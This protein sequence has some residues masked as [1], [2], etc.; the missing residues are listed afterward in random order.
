MHLT[1]VRVGSLN[2]AVQAV[3]TALFEE[4]SYHMLKTNDSESVT[5]DV[6]AG[7]YRH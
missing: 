2:D 5:F 3:I 4:S 6:A 1:E 7:E